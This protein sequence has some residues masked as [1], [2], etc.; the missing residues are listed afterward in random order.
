MTP[1]G[2]TCRCGRDNA[3]RSR[4]TGQSDSYR[5]IH[6][7]I[8]N[9]KRAEIRPCQLRATSRYHRPHASSRDLSDCPRTDREHLFTRPCLRPEGAR[10]AA[11][12][13]VLCHA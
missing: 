9:L 1:L 2:F 6:G 8:S 10:I 11:P 13:A 12:G 4:S 3:L 7:Q 5:P